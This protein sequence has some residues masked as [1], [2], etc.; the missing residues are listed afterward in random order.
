MVQICVCVQVPYVLVAWARRVGPEEQVDG[1]LLFL[2]S[3]RIAVETPEKRERAVA[4]ALV[5]VLGVG[6]EEQVDGVLLI[7]VCV[8]VAVE[9]PAKR[10]RA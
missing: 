5:L 9:T 4:V 2:V 6:P 8:H 3:V 1:V 10:E 7:L